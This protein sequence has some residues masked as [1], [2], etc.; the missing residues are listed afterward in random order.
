MKKDNTGLIMATMWVEKDS[1][2]KLGV[3]AK[4]QGISRALMVRQ[5]MRE[6]VKAA[7]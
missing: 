5:W 3:I 7:K 1:W 6:A 4:K 2:K